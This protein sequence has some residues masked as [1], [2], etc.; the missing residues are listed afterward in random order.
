[1]ASA[2]TLGEGGSGTLDAKDRAEARGVRVRARA[3]VESGSASESSLRDLL[4]D[5]LK[6]DASHVG[7]LW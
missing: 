6:R 3:R 1:M 2:T 5:M 7:M 4:V